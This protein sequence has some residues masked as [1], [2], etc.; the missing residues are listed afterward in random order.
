MDGEKGQIVK[1]SRG[2]FNEIS[3][4]DILF[5]AENIYM[6]AAVNVN[7]NAGDGIFFS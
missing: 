3:N 2:N 4:K 7:E 1:I 5:K 6:T